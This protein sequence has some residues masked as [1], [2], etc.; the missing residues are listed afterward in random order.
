MP[1]I[2]SVHES[3][4]YIDPEPSAEQRAAAEALIAEERALVPDDPHHALLRPPYEPRFTE[5]MRAEI[6][7]VAANQKLDK[8][9]QK[10]LSAIDLSRYEAQEELPANGSAASLRS[11]LANAYTSQAYLRSRRAHL[12]LLDSYG[13]N[14]WLVGNWQVETELRGV[15]AELAQ[16]RR[17][18]DITTLRR[19][20]AQNEAA[21]ELQSLEETWRTGIGRVLETEAA[22]EDLRQQCLDARRRQ[23]ASEV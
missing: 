8:K 1:Y 6:D 14:A 4:P 18:I 10:P 12:A 9:D 11:V 5:A 16:T 19:Q 2:T 7:R 17:H 20:R 22:A 13:K 21:P 15:E 23:V 3:L